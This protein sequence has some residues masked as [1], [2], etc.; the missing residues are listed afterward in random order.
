MNHITASYTADTRGEGIESPNHRK[1]ATK[2]RNI[3]QEVNYHE[4]NQL[5]HHRNNGSY[6]QH[7]SR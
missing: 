7:S 2:P 5:N 6:L 1:Q 4:A 3:M